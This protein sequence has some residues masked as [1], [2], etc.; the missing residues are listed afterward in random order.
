[1]NSPKEEICRTL[2]TLVRFGRFEALAPLLKQ[3]AAKKGGEA[4]G[5]IIKELDEGGHSIL[6]WAAK[7]VD[8][9]RFL[10]TLIDLLLELKLATLINT[11][12]YVRSTVFLSFLNRTNHQIENTHSP[13]HSNPQQFR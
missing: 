7:R 4:M 1:V 11:P 10:Q 8:D 2:C 9:L 12:R 6:H 5:E 13:T 3:L